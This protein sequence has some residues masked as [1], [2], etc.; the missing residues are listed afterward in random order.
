MTKQYCI[1]VDITNMT[2]EQRMHV[3]GEH[4]HKKGFIKLSKGWSNQH[5]PK[6]RMWY[7]FWYEGEKPT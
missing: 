5:T 3:L 6:E 4:I 2:F 7:I 1:D